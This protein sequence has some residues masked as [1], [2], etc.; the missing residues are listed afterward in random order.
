MY[1][2]RQDPLK[3]SA[4]MILKN[5]EKLLPRCLGSIK[6]HVDEIIVVDTGS[7]D[8]TV[9]IAQSFGAKVYHHPW[10]HHFSKHRNQSLDYA[11]GDWLFIID[12][13][14]E[15]LP[16]RGLSLQQAL[17]TGEDI[18][19]ALIPVECASP[20]GIIQA[21][22]VRFFKNHKGIHY[23]GR[24]HNDLMGIKRSLFLD[25]VRLFH[26]GYNLGQ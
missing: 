1:N 25:E 9:S 10:E 20:T 5:E 8:K 24:V 11:T 17:Q 6:D 15:L 23:Q 19:S 7:R 2:P 4:C 26:H 18:D 13:D 22:S 21:N 14:E 12:A 3:I 16:H